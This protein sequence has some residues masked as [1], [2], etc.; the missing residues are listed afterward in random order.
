M[1]ELDSSRLL[2]IGSARPRPLPDPP[3]PAP[4]AVLD[5]PVFVGSVFV[6]PALVGPGFRG[7][8]KLYSSD[9]SRLSNS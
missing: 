6:G 1:S 4:P 2:A 8:R 7:S 9:K 5:R 3:L